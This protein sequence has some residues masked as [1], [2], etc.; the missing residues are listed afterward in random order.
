MVV[1]EANA[2]GTV[3]DSLLLSS[4]LHTMHTG[5][6]QPHV[7]SVRVWAWLCPH[8]SFPTIKLLISAG[9]V[10]E[11]PSP[12]S[13]LWHECGRAQKAEQRDAGPNNGAPHKA[14]LRLKCP[15]SVGRVPP[16]V[17]DPE[18]EQSLRRGMG[19]AHLEVEPAAVQYEVVRCRTGLSHL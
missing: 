10:P 3:P 11:M 5:A 17:V 19:T 4:L 8:S 12:S 15:I 6:A 1:D 9:I 16:M 14:L 18:H 7:R 2:A 13:L